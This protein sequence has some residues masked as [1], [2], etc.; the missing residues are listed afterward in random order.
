MMSIMLFGISIILLY[1]I[2]QYEY[3]IFHSFAELFSV[4]IACGIFMIAWNSRAF[5]NNNYLLFIGITYLFVAFF[6]TLHTLAYHGMGVFKGYDDN[7]LPPQLWLVAR[8][9]ESI[10]LVAAPLF[11]RRALPTGKVIA[12]FSAVSLI[13]IWSI[14]F[15]RIFPTCFVAGLGLTPFKR[16]SE[17]VIDLLLVAALVML[18]REKKRFDPKVLQLLT[19]SIICTIAVELFFTFYINL[20]G[21]SNF[22]G[23]IFK[24]LS[25]G[26]MYMA[27][28]KTALE[29]PYSL[30]FRELKQNEATLRQKE[31]LLQLAQ[32]LAHLGS[33]EWNLKDDSMWWSDEMYKLFDYEMGV[34]IPSLELE[35]ARVHPDDMNSVNQAIINFLRE[36]QPFKL[37]HRIVRTNGDIRYVAIEFNKTHLDQTG[38]ADVAMGIVQDITEQVLF[39]KTREDIELITRHDLRTPLNPI[40]NIPELLLTDTNIT[41]EQIE[42]IQL[43]RSSGYRMLNIIDSS[44]SLYKME[45]RTYTL[46]PVSF[47][48]LPL[49]SDIVR[50]FATELDKNRL[51]LV[52]RLNDKLVDEGD[53]F[54]LS[55]EVLLCYTMLSNLIKNAIEASPPDEVITVSCGQDEVWNIIGIHNS[56]AVPEKIRTGFFDKYVTHGKNTG[57]GLGTYSASLAAKTQKGD[58]SMTTS[59]DAGTLITVRLPITV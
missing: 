50:E 36:K 7:N 29:Q 10:A 52:C 40:I 26:F 38:T 12:F 47:N 24:I 13:S 14:F 41:P 56:G 27:I 42:W 55:G 51:K 3:L 17:Y 6:D 58:I 59:E 54:M 4:A 19:L 43:I 1:L 39:A 34:A 49:I 44:L 2:A 28:I 30:L 16:G 48:L 32:N 46:M 53:T 20:Y 23:H 9:I 11:L 33:W 31:E 18:H 21:F 57:T 8:Y 5:Y 37:T 25:F 35:M 22:V 45:Q 15:A